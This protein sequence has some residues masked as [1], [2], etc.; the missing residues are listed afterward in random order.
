MRSRILP[1]LALVATSTLLFTACKHRRGNG[2]IVTVERSVDPFERVEVHGAIDVHVSQGPQQP[3]RIEADENLQKYILVSERGGEL[4]I[5]TKSG[6]S[7]SPSRKMKVYVTSPKYEKLD[8]SGACNIIGETKISSSDRLEIGVSGAGNIN[9]DVDAPVVKAGISGAG[10]VQLR[11]N[12]RDFSLELSGAAKANCYDLR[13]ET[14]RV[15]I[16]GAGAAEVFASV[17]LDADV[18]GAGNVRYRGNATEVRQNVS[19]A[20]SVKKAD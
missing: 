17:R 14:T 19:G 20:G 9:M 5:R 13:S 2:N 11:G 8:V 1:L 18:S 7:L 10:K 6:V 16:S 4:E 3:V 15:E 12:T